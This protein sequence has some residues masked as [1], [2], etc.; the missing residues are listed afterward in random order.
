MTRTESAAVEQTI[1]PCSD[2][3]FSNGIVQNER[4]SFCHIAKVDC[5][6]IRNRKGL[7]SVYTSRRLLRKRDLQMSN[8]AE[9]NTLQLYR[10]HT[11]RTTVTGNAS[12]LCVA[13][14]E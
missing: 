4:S 6:A 12:P 9:P 11:L 7:T 10:H 14:K 5:R 13:M 3:G 1:L 2:V 8:D